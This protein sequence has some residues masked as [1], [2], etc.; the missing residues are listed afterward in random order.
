MSTVLNI[1]FDNPIEY[2]G[3]RRRTFKTRPK[4]HMQAIR[5]N[6]GNSWHCNHILNI[7]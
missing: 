2:I 4:E 5:N 7:G 3:Q 6:N 1:L